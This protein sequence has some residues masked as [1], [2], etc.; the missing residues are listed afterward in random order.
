M[1]MNA[2]KLLL[3]TAVLCASTA[4]FA[5]GEAQEA[6]A[7]KEQVEVKKAADTK[8]TTTSQKPADKKWWQFW[9]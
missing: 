9:K 1:K 5:K 6:P 2:K 4:V 3:L 7:Q 8:G